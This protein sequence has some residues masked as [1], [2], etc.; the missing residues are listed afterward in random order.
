MKDKEYVAL[1]YMTGI[2]PVKKYGKHSALNM[3]YEYSMISPMQLAPYTGFTKKE[4]MQLCEKYGRGYDRIKEWYDGYEVSDIV[5]SALETQGMEIK[6]ATKYSLYSPLSVATAIWTGYVKNYWNKTETYEALAEY[7]RMNLDGLKDAVVLMMDGA[8]VKADISGYQNDMTTF[9]SKDD[10][11]ALLIHLG[12]LG[13]DDETQ[14][15]FIPNKE[16]L[17]EFKTSTKT[18]EWTGTL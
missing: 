6:Q 16:I 7:I 15:V 1:A 13:Y 8:R 11:L 10:V 3:F 18:A 9:H 5:P 14:E 4:V 12:Y 17:D 2:L